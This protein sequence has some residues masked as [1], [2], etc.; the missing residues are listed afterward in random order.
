MKNIFMFWVGDKD[1]IKPLV[2]KLEKMNFNVVVGPTKEDSNYLMSFDFYKNSHEQKIWSFC[3]DV[4]RVWKLSTNIGLYIDTSVMV[5]DD[6]PSFFDITMKYKSYFVRENYALIASAILGSSIENN[7]IYEDLLN[8]YETFNNVDVRQYHIAPHI[9]TKYLI[10]KYNLN[11]GWNIY[12]NNNIFVDDFMS[13]RNQSTI[14]KLGGSSWL[15]GS[16]KSD[17]FQSHEE[18][19]QNRKINKIRFWEMQRYLNYSYEEPWI[20]GIRTAYDKSANKQERV[21]LQRIYKT[22]QGHV[23]LKQKLIWSKM[24]VFFNK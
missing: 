10:E 21:R 19:W 11:F 18:N 24:F 8:I 12:E 14:K 13:I 3:S 16:Q 20:I 7:E 9:I 15:G 4:W 2:D 6:F 23:P 1:K 5:G 17:P 22:I